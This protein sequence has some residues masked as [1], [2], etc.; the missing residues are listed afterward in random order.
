M[1]QERFEERKQ[2]LQNAIQRLEESVLAPKS[3]IVRDSA[4]QR[5]EFTFELAWKAL[6]LYL[7]NQGLE[8]GSPRQAI[9]NAFQQGIFRDEQ[10]TEAWLKMLEDRNLT[11]HTYQEKLAEDIYSRIASAHLPLLKSL[12]GKLQGLAWQ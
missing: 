9:K 7:E 5:F 8:S 11:S 3:D 1:S 12:A 6:Q 10:E 2:E 4:I